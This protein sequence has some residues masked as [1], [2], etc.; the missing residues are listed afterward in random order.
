MENPLQTAFCLSNVEILTFCVTV[1]YLMCNSVLLRVTILFQ[2][3]WIFV[4]T[5]L[6]VSLWC[7][8]RLCH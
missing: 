3:W 6:C 1:V 7:V 2:C 5:V 8:M 4:F